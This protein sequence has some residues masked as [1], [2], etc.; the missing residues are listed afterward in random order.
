MLH[1]C[2][3]NRIGRRYCTGHAVQ[4]FTR[5]AAAANCE[6]WQEKTVRDV[7]HL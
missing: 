2:V 6:R 3:R 1:C 7:D 5:L 4:L